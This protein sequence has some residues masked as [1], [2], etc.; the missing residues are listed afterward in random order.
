MYKLIF[1]GTVLMLPRSVCITTAL[2]VKFFDYY[3]I[4]RQ[5]FLTRLQLLSSLSNSCDWALIIDIT[6]LMISISITINSTTPGNRV[7]LF[8]PDRSFLKSRE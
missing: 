1:P 3:G 8:L 6:I 4:G 7:Y 2:V 5:V